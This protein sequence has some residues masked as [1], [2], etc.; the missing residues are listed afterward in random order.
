MVY[1]SMK[2]MSTTSW[3]SYL[4]QYAP[5]LQKDG[6]PEEI[7]R[8]RE[9]ISYA[10]NFNPQAALFASS[11]IPLHPRLLYFLIR[12]CE[13]YGFDLLGK[14]I[15]QRFPK[16]SFW[17]YHISNLNLKA[18]STSVLGL[19]DRFQNDK[20]IYESVFEFF[21]HINQL[22]IGFKETNQ[23]IQRILFSKQQQYQPDQINHFVKQYL[24]KWIPNYSIYLPAVMKRIIVLDQPITIDFWI[25]SLFILTVEYK[26]IHHQECT[27]LFQQLLDTFTFIFTTPLSSSDYH[28]RF[29]ADQ[30]YAITE[31]VRQ[32]ILSGGNIT[33]DQIV[34]I[35]DLI[36]QT[37]Q[38]ILSNAIMFQYPCV[39]QLIKTLVSM[40]SQWNTIEMIS[41]RVIDRVVD[42]INQNM[43]LKYRLLNHQSSHLIVELVIDFYNQAKIIP[44][45]E[46]IPTSEWID[47]GI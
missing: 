40:D 37:Q 45:T 35:I 1:I 31:I 24:I 30:L 19:L 26:G 14:H 34:Q 32:I 41:S 6:R 36:V 46:K 4:P 16:D 43:K 2:Y 25:D 42:W 18:L 13:H 15:S 33:T 38:L 21:N 11:D 27:V 9:F 22:G 5:V 23:L 20:D 12:A 17:Q 10:N 44:T 39:G 29:L 47:I 8:V 3:S 28:L 7:I